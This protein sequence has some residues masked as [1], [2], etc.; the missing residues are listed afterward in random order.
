MSA[1]AG[2]LLSALLAP[3]CRKRREPRACN[4]SSVTS[5]SLEKD[6]IRRNA[7]HYAATFRILIKA[8]LLR[9]H[10]SQKPLGRPRAMTEAEFVNLP[11][12]ENS[13]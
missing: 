4:K 8:V 5:C 2:H 10:E 3:A 1:R 12:K 11:K 13:H 7:Q 9:R 6:R